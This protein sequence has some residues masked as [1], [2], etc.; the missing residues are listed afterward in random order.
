[1]AV[2]IIDNTE[3]VLSQLKTAKGVALHMVGAA[4]EKHAVEILQ[5][6]GAVDT[7]RLLNDITHIED[8]DYSYIGTAVKY[9]VYV[10]LGTGIFASQGNGRKTPWKYRDSKGHWNTTRGMKPRPFLKPAATKYRSEYL[11]I[12]K[13]VFKGDV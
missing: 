2:S 11:K 13:S 3:L 12:F 5:E 9:G 4:A 6:Q 10:E 1:M 8:D 7:G